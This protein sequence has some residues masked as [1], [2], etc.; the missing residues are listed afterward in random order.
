ME[1]TLGREDMPIEK[2]PPPHCLQ[3]WSVTLNRDPPSPKSFKALHGSPF[4]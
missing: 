4:F 1:R 3:S 2:S